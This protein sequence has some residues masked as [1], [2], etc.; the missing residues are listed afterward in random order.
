[1]S[2][3]TALQDVIQHHFNGKAA[4]LQSFV[5]TGYSFEEW[6]NWE[7]FYALQ[8]SESDL[9]PKP[10]YRHVT[11]LQASKKTGD[12]YFTKGGHSY[13]VEVALVHDYTSDKKWRDKVHWDRDQLLTLKGADKVI[14]IQL[15]VLVS[16]HDD[17]EASS[18]WMN[19][20]K[21]LSFWGDAKDIQV[22]IRLPQNGQAWIVGWAV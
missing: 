17:M 16:N 14:P 3:F 18:D 7:L 4:E 6:F 15:L 21:S 10:A 2:T 22:K 20:L 13:I 11:D 12:V 19:W 8:V 5:K 9:K 1:L